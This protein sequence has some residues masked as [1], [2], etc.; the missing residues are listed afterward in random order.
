MEDK[1][2]E[3]LRDY[4]GVINELMFPCYDREKLNQNILKLINCFNINKE[5]LTNTN[6]K[7][8]TIGCNVEI[9]LKYKN[10]FFKKRRYVDFLEDTISLCEGIDWDYDY[11]I[12]NSPLSMLGDAIHLIYFKEYVK[13]YKETLSIQKDFKIDNCKDCEDTQC[14]YKYSL[15]NDK[16]WKLEYTNPCS[17]CLVKEKYPNHHYFICGI[18][19]HGIEHEN[20]FCQKQER[21]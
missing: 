11:E 16:R 14:M 8:I 19:N 21:P 3:V 5:T 10:Q 17:N 4:I 15:E 9:I 2:F 12:G 20:S 6:L 1:E 13:L 7:Q 18:C